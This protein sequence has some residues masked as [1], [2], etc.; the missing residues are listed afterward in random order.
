MEYRR[1]NGN[2]WN[3]SSETSFLRMYALKLIV[4]DIVMLVYDIFLLY[5]YIN[6]FVLYLNTECFQGDH[7]T[8]PLKYSD[9]I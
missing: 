9:S 5:N 4:E 7:S 8:P 3:Y 6:M 2:L 1:Q